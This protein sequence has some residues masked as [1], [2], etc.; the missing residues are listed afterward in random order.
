MSL[1]SQQTFP[2]PWPKSPGSL[3]SIYAT[4]VHTE[5]MY[6]RRRKVHLSGEI[7]CSPSI[8]GIAS[9]PEALPYLIADVGARLTSCTDVLECRIGGPPVWL[10]GENPPPE[11]WTT[12]GTC[13]QPMP[14]VLQLDAGHEGCASCCTAIRVLYLFGCNNEECSPTLTLIGNIT[15]RFP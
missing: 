7:D 5:R 9:A 10:E 8:D 15:P 3:E 2:A 11:A 12:C 6:E 1:F 13:N 14:L 4:G